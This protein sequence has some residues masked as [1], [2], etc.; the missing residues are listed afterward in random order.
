VASSISTIRHGAGKRLVM[1]VPASLPVALAHPLAPKLRV[2]AERCESNSRAKL[3]RL[4]T[5]PH[6][7]L[8]GAFFGRMDMATGLRDVGSTWGADL[9]LALTSRRC[10]P[11]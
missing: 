4:A 2:R 3:R 11:P 10:V 7:E 9:E 6:L 8:K 5:S 1:D